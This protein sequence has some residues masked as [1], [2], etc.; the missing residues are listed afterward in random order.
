L[1]FSAKYKHPDPGNFGQK[2]L[3]GILNIIYLTTR[4]SVIHTKSKA[5]R[6]SVANFTCTPKTAINRSNQ[7]K[8]LSSP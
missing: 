5:D 8:L 1:I 3:C 7:R 6:L 2:S 4:K